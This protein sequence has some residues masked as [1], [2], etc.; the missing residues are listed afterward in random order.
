ML[1]L[2]ITFFFFL[3]LLPSFSQTING[4]ITDS[5]GVGLPF[6]T[7]TLLNFPDSSV[8]AGVVSDEQ[9]LFYMNSKFDS[10]KLLRCSAIGYKT[11]TIYITPKDTA[12][13][14]IK[15]TGDGLTLSE[16]S[17][18]AIKNII[19]VKNGNII[20]NIANSPLAKGNTV[21][22]LFMTLPG[23]SIE[24]NIIFLNGKPGVLI[25]VDGRV[26]QVSNAQL[27]NMLK[28]MNVESIEKIELFKNPPVE[29]D[30][31]GT[32]GIISI[33]TKKVK[34]KGFSGTVYTSASQGF[35]GRASGGASLNYKSNKLTIFSN[36]D[37]NYSLYQVLANFNRT[38]H[39]DTSVTELQTFNNMKDIETGLSYRFG[40]DW[41]INDKTT[42][43][44]KIDGGPGSYVSNSVGTTKVRQKNDL[45]F[46]HL[47]SSVVNPDRW[48]TNNL[49]VN[50]ERLLD[51]IGS[52]VRFT[53]DY[54]ILSQ[55]VTSNIQNHFLN[56]DETE[57]LPPNIYRNKNENAT[58]ILASKLDYEK[59]LKKESSLQIG[60]K[61]SL[62]ST[63]NKYLFEQMDNSNG[64]Y[65]KDTTLTNNYS[66]EEQTYAAYASFNRK[67][68]K[69]SFQA[70]LRFENTNLVG[71]NTERAF[72]IEKSY[73]NVFPNLSF[74]YE[75]SETQTI[76][77]NFNR[78]IDRPQYGDLNPFRYY[79][80]QYQFYE[81]NPFLLPHY[82]NT[83]DFTHTYKKS[84][85]NSFTFTRID[86]VMLHYTKQ[87]D[88]TKVF[89]ES[90]KNMKISNTFS[91]LLFIQKKLRSWWNVTVNGVV[92]YIA[93]EG[94]IEK[95]PFKTASFYYNPSLINTFILPKNLKLE[96]LSFYRSGKNNGLVQVR[97]RWMVSLAIKKV[98]V[99]DK[100]DFSVGL[101]DVFY[102]GY[103][104]T[105]AK[106]N[107]QDWNYRVTQDTR[108]ITVSLNYNFGR[109]K[110]DI[111]EISSNEQE[112]GRLSH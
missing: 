52:A 75:I 68:R 76:Q 36:L 29:F 42:L 28:S 81:G 56:S 14:L 94:D 61:I 20:V 72:R 34:I 10:Q 41:F 46:D 32:S 67:I 19:E 44:F 21:Y 92:S 49:N 12:P 95:V 6:S 55:N 103:F 25:M 85:T 53:S 33:R 63:S 15:L 108:R 60:T 17:I 111:R 88:S 102:T 93:Y 31:A 65:I 84:V 110:A 43:G 35:Y 45:G 4:H 30:A 70:G 104:Q 27:L 105:W 99:K 87:N 71:K 37:C 2:L 50:A 38:F 83:I 26:Q 1:K 80:D 39:N 91:Y 86:N 64:Q 66:Y 13:L 77:L 48:S 89:I 23:V 22:D 8:I 109:V 97:P 57:V 16:I 98:V 90:F 24:D 5:S 3:Q 106:F 54:T 51:T 100:L 82:S 79:R 59:T 101:N 58:W 9:G 62:I 40:A 7:V 11:K 69:T 112:K 107:N 96:I 47:N 74:E 18:S 78:R 73:Y